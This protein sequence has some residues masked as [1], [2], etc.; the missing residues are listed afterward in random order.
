METH[1]SSLDENMSVTCLYFLQRGAEPSLH[2]LFRDYPSELLPTYPIASF[3][4]LHYTFFF[5]PQ[6]IHKGSQVVP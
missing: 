5:F 4:L 1:N 2:D 6:P 3:P